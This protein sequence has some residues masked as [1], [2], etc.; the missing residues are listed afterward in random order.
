MN[1]QPRTQ[2]RALELVVLDMD[3]AGKPTDEQIAEKWGLASARSVR[4]VRESQEYQHLL[5]E[6]QSQALSHVGEEIAA[7]QSLAVQSLVSLVP[8]LADAAARLLSVPEGIPHAE[9][10]VPKYTDVTAANGAINT[11]IKLANIGQASGMAEVSK[12]QH[13][14]QVMPDLRRAKSD[15]SL[16]R[17]QYSIVV[18]RLVQDRDEEDAIEGDYSLLQTMDADV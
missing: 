9:R 13:A 11:I 8:K 16:I 5:A 3:V 12:Q 1:S 7:M 4:E 2:S 15:S 14:G 18:E 17:E 6:L 10:W